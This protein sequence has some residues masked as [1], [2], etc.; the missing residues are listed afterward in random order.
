LSITFTPLQKTHFSLL[1]KWLYA[2]HVREWWDKEVSWTPEL[3]EKKYT[4]YTEGF[5]I[6]GDIKMPMH[7][8]VIEVDTFPVGYIQYY[9]KYDFPPEQGYAIEGL[10]DSLAAIDFYI[11]EESYLGKN[12][13]SRA[14]KDFLNQHVFKEFDTCFVDPDISNKAAIRTYERA[15][16]KEVKKIPELAITWMLARF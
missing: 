12:I 14:L 2:P 10:P 8:F 4:S 11:G 5:K 1:L 7:A 15:G 13:G 6:L 3:V 9:N 16:F